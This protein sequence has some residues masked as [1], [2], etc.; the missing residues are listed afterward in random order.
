M[1]A[2]EKRMNMIQKK[3]TFLFGAG[4]EGKG[5]LG[6]CS[7]NEYKEQMI[8]CDKIKE[9]IT[10]FD[11]EL[12][13]KIRND[14]L[15]TWNSSGILYQTIK[16]NFK[17]DGIKLEE[18]NRD[19]LKKIIK[20]KLKVQEDD[21]VN[22]ILNYLSY[23]ELNNSYEPNNKTYVIN[24][25]QKLYREHIYDFIKQN[26]KEGYKPSA[27]YEY[28]IENAEPCAYYDS[29]FNYLRE[30]QLYCMEVTKVQKIYYAALKVVCKSI[31]D[32]ISKDRYIAYI[33]ELGECRGDRKKIFASFGKIQN[34]LL[35]KIDKQ[36]DVNLYYESVKRLNQAM[37]QNDKEHNLQI[38]IVTTN[39]TSFAEK[40]TGIS[41]ENIVY[42]HG[43]LGEFEDVNSKRIDTL[44]RYEEG[45]YNLFPYLLVQSG[46]KPI[47]NFK[48]L[49]SLYRGGLHLLDADELVILGYG[50]NSD[51]EHIVNIL[52][53][54][55]R[56]R[57]KIV[58]FY[59]CRE[60]ADKKDT[61]NSE[62]NR[63][64]ELLF[65]KDKRLIDIRDADE[66]DEYI[67]EI[68]DTKPD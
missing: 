21:L 28:F 26:K 48:Q 2:K 45:E 39:Y 1:V 6:I 54:R 40:I 44:D 18:Q 42:M 64:K 63:L 49:D 25:F 16:E 68:A 57:K 65:V 47:I 8:Q 27:L 14:M 36:N 15:V 3:Y 55:M 37:I 52:R 19:E 66:F 31:C 23:K 10:I 61:L 29:L 22:I 30:P 60:H 34:E 56:N 50:L 43:E 46:V 32:A 41:K 38:D 35:E 59:Y 33:D 13:S 62:M 5:Q 12:G 9:F 24:K 7:G 51:D 17:I 4:A 20:D 11:K 53:E 67:N 58:Y